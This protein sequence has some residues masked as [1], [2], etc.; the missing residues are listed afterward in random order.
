MAPTLNHDNGPEERERKKPLECFLELFPSK[1]ISPMLT[2]ENM[3]L[4]IWIIHDLKLSFPSRSGS[5]RCHCLCSAF[6]VSSLTLWGLPSSNTAALTCRESRN[7]SKV[8]ARETC[9]WK[10]IIKHTRVSPWK[11]PFGQRGKRSWLL[12]CCSCV[13][14][15]IHD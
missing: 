15:L 4:A 5:R 1:M 8:L 14:L 9:K 13:T 6:Q 7:Q 11:Q 3:P 10:G 12:K 2:L